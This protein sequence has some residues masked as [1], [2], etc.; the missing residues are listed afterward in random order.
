MVEIIVKNEDEKKEGEY[1][2]PRKT[3]PNKWSDS[4]NMDVD[5]GKSKVVNM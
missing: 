4:R 1:T 2:F 5:G 3:A